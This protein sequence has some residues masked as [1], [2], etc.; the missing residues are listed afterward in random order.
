[1]W[2]KLGLGIKALMLGGI[3]LFVNIIASY[4]HG[5]VDLTEENRFTLT[6]ATRNLL[7]STN[8]VVLVHVLL[9]GDFPAGFKRLQQST[10]EILDQFASESSYIEYVFEDPN[11]GSVE[12]INTRRKELTKEGLI[13]TNLM[14]R[15]GSENKEQIIFPYAILSLGE[16][17]VA[18]NLLESS[19]ELNQDENLANSISLLEYKLAHGLQNLQTKE[20]KNV[21]ITTGHGE[22]DK[23]QTQSLFGNLDLFYNVGYVNLD[24]VPVLKKEID[25]VIMAKPSLALSE[26]N[27]FTLDQYIMN[28]GKVIFLI[29]RLAMSLDSLNTRKEYIPEPLEL[30]LEDLLFRYGFRIEP[31]FVLDLECSRIPQVI[32]SQG[33]KP[34]I[35]LF[36]WYYH[37]LLSGYGDHPIVQNIDRVNSEFPSYID[38]LK[39]KTG[40]RHTI[41]ITSSQYSRYQLAPTKID[42]EILHYKPDPS[43]FNKPHLPVAV[44]G[45]GIFPSLYEN[46][47]DESMKSNLAN[48][49]LDFKS[50]SKPTSVL[51]VADGDIAKNLVD[52]ETGKFSPLGYSKWERKAFNGN[53]DFLL[54]SV[55]YM[56]NPDN[57]LA[58]RSKEFR[59]RLLDRVKAENEKMKWQLINIGLPIFLLIITG[60]INH[61]IRKK[62]FIKLPTI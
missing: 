39:T 40:V 22:L 54:N 4:I 28:G 45:E 26:K 35:E 61:Y 57:V 43:K 13:P 9:E 49:Q 32:G 51:V 3:L 55:D 29:D 21:L 48:L 11:V 7:R 60:L 27:K 6:Q 12:E 53:K 24:S 34:Q 15:T 36:P 46:R 42:F 33:G 31:A 56:I 23:D 19:A 2:K 20:F 14:V 37:P 50:M 1:M 44:L 41:L 8:N 58:A 59:I 16:R 52:K 5:Y 38:T 25:L 62:K 17:K 10:K 30:N 18:V 47:V